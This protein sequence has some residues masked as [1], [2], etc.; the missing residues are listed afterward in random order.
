M[1]TGRIKGVSGIFRGYSAGVC[2]ILGLG[3]VRIGKLKSLGDM[4]HKD[5]EKVQSSLIPGIRQQESRLQEA[6][7]GVQQE[8]D[9][10]LDQARQQAETSLDKVRGD[11]SASVARLRGAGLEALQQELEAERA[12]THGAIQTFEAQTSARL[13]EAVHRIMSLVLPG[14]KA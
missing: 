13:P 6:L 12:G 14:G 2:G 3:N 8:A 11:F 1:N 9:A 4:K 5:E 10:L 7:Q